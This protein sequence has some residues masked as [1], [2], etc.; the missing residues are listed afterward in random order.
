MEQSTSLTGTVLKV[1]TRRTG[2]SAKGKPWACQHLR[3][4][5][6]GRS[7]DVEIWNEADLSELK[8]KTVRCFGSHV[9][10]EYEGKTYEKFITEGAP[11][12]VNG[13]GEEGDPADPAA[14]SLRVNLLQAV[15]LL[16]Q[17]HDITK[18]AGLTPDDG[19]ALF[20]VCA[21]LTKS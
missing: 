8:G 21:R 1:L 5:A 9:E 14:N 4:A 15:A 20:A 12:L 6:E 3:L 18:D 19:R 2:T 17:C 16:T 11:Q 10:Q 7:H 13:N